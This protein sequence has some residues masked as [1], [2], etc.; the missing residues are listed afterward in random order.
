MGI[1][2]IEALTGQAERPVCPEC[3][4]GKCTNCDGVAWNETSDVPDQ[5]ACEESLHGIVKED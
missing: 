2:G 1:R 5:C 4:Q 3:K